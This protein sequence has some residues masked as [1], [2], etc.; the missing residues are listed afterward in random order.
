MQEESKQKVDI[1]AAVKAKEAEPERD[2]IKE[3]V[4]K[5]T[6]NG[7]NVAALF[8]DE[9]NQVDTLL[10]MF[11][12]KVID[13]DGKD[14]GYR[15]PKQKQTEALKSMLDAPEV[16]KPKNQ[17]L[18]N[19]VQKTVINDELIQKNVG[20]GLVGPKNDIL[21]TALDLLSQGIS[22][23]PIG[24]NKVPIIQWKEFHDR[25]ATEEEVK[26]WFTGTDHQL[27][28][29]TGPIS[30]ISVVDFEK[31]YGDHTKKGLP[32]TS[33]VRTGGGGVHLYYAHVKGVK[34]KAKVGG[35]EI[36]W[37]GEGGY[38]VVPPSISDK[39]PYTW[40]KKVDDLPP[41]P[42][43]EFP[44]EKPENKPITERTLEY[45][46]NDYPGFGQGQRNNEMT[47][48]IG[49]LLSG[50]KW[51][52]WEKVAWPLVEEANEK[53]DPPL[54]QAELLATYKSVEKLEGP[55]SL[56][57]WQEDILEKK[58]NERLEM[59][60][61]I[62][63]DEIVTLKEAA[64]KIRALN[65]QTYSTGFAKFDNAMKGG[66][67]E[68]DLVVVSGMSGHGKTTLGQ[69]F[70]YNLIN[71]DLPIL[72]FSYEVSADI[73]DEKFQ[74]MGVS[75]DYKVYVPEVTATGDMIWVENKIKEA[76]K[77]FDVKCVFVD[78]IDFLSPKEQKR[79]D[80]EALVLRR[81]TSELKN[82]AR[83]QRVVVF[84][85]AHVR[86]QKDDKKGLENQD[87]AHSSS[88]VQ[89]SDYVFMIERS[90]SGGKKK[91]ETLMDEDGVPVKTRSI[92]EYST[93]S[94]IRITKNRY[95]GM[96][97]AETCKLGDDERFH[98]DAPSV[99]SPEVDKKTDWMNK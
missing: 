15:S 23:I 64:E 8:P 20:N 43:D 42:V 77:K 63:G 11:G 89:L 79:S 78:L 19:N 33:A 36:D 39:G 90:I 54:N 67:K 47:R 35:E 71:K 40:I 34:N 74:A 50:M 2:E 37:R 3:A 25:L 18:D 85:M 7:K 97:V 96:M 75:K 46:L 16:E 84:V 59:L 5:I 94:Q 45:D 91:Q 88:I 62:E 99:K 49:S 92:I 76:I 72:W 41:F 29:V 86:K 82:I 13:D 1:F 14:T 70:T 17:I 48:Y 73:L 93:Y 27:G 57:K 9:P 98:T 24:P 31:E 22:V 81:I 51:S 53:N 83:E 87:I 58:K 61:A 28:M 60:D 12:G 4:D 10:D 55:K 44:E 38:V 65:P 52:L 66:F 30:G 95:T 26:E 32:E 56:E 68:G 69:T 80:S 21:G 6:D